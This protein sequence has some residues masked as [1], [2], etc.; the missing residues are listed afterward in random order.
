MFSSF[1][2]TAGADAEK[3]FCSNSRFL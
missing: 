1:F 3:P 2:S